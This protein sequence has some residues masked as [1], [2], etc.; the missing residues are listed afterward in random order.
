VREREVANRTREAGSLDEIQ[1][2]VANTLM[3]FCNG[4]VGFIDWL[5][6]TLKNPH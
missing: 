3:L 4:A 5:D 1:G 2:V 6:V